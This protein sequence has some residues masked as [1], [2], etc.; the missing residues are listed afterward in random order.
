MLSAVPRE[1]HDSIIGADPKLSLGNARGFD[2]E[3]RIGCLG[4]RTL[5]CHTTAQCFVRFFVARK[6]WTDAFPGTA[7]IVRCKQRVATN[8][9]QTPVKGIKCERPQLK[10]YRRFAGATTF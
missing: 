4:A 1:L 7:A 2:V 10:R 9:R 6:V 8:E 5:K 3:N